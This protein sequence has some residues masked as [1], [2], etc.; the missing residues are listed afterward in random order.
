MDIA[1]HVAELIL[2]SLGDMGY[3]LVRVQFTGT[4]RRT[5]QIM[6]ERTDRGAMTVEDCAEISRAASALLDVDDPIAGQYVLEVSSPGLDRPLTR[7]EDFAR[8]AGFAAKLETVMPV[9]GRKRFSGRI[10][11]LNDAGAVVLASEESGEVI[12]PF[13]NVARAKLMLTDDLIKAAEKEQG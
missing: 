7:V 12:V 6:A 13:S 11:G 4:T 10:V 1:R 5:L 8:F 2:P 9:S 3:E